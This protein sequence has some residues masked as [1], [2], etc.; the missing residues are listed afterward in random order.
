MSLPDVLTVL[1]SREINCGLSCF[2]DGGWDVWIGDELNGFCAAATVD[3]IADAA[4]WFAEAAAVI[5]PNA[6]LPWAAPASPRRWRP[7]HAKQTPSRAMLKP[8]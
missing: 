8:V 5:F 2:W 3:L 7:D 4:V 1:Y 6:D